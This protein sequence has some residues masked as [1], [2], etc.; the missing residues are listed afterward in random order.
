MLELG[1]RDERYRTTVMRVACTGYLL[2]AGVVVAECVAG[3]DPLA[4]G[5]AVVPT[6]TTGLAIG[7]ALTLGGAGLVALAGLRR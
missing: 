4:P 3:I 2:F 1:G 5:A 7:G 6:V